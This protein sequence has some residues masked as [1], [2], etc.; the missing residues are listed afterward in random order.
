MKELHSRSV[1]K[2]VTWRI[3]GTIDTIVIAFVLTGRLSLA[4]SIGSIEIVTKI[5]LYYFHERL[6]SRISWGRISK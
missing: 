5:V 3:T 1:L 4:L 2:G 6:W